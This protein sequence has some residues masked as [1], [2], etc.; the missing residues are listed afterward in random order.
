M[1]N[2]DQPSLF[3]FGVKKIKNNEETETS[4]NINDA[5]KY[6][7][8]K[9]PWTPPKNYQFPIE[10]QR[11][12]KF[13]FDWLIR[14][15]WLVYSEKVQGALCKCCVLFANN[16][17]GKRIHHK[18]GAL[19]IKPFTKWKDAIERFNRHSNSEYHK[20]SIIR[21]EEFIKVMEN[22][23]NNIANEI[24]I[25]RKKQVIENRSI[26]RLIIETL[27][28]CGKQNIALRGNNDSGKI[29]D[30]SIE[31]NDGNFRSLLRFKSLT[32]PILDKHLKNA[33]SFA[34]YTSPNVQNEII[35][36]C[37]DETQDVSRLEQ[38]S[39]CVRY[40]DGVSNC[41]MEDFLEFSIVHDMTGKGLSTSILQ[42]LEKFGLE[43]K[44]LVGQGYDGAASMSGQFNGVQQYIREAVP[45]ALFVHCASH[46]LN[47]AVGS[48]CKIVSIRNCIGT[49]SSVIT[50]FR[51]SS[52]RT[53]TLIESLHVIEKFFSLTLPLSIALQKVNIDL[54]YCYERVTDVC[55]IF[56]EIRE[57][58]DDE[59]KQIFS[60]VEESMLEGIIEVPRTVGRQTAQIKI[61]L[62][63]W[64][65]VSDRDRPTTSLTTLSA[66]SYDF[67]PNIH[68]LLTI[69]ATLPVTTATAERSFSTLRRLKT[70]LRNNMGETR[71]TGLALLNIYRNV[72][73]NVEEIIDRFAMLPRKWDFIL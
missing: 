39:F 62:A 54:S 23:K 70:Y 9:N 17:V 67:F 42:L 44:F 32:D 11:R 28:L 18:L 35:T 21:S 29:Y 19:I 7:L 15:P 55:Q 2:S 73:L 65:N 12:L 8:L 72:D 41:I 14:F 64:K 58:G 37:V 5:K 51:A 6:E 49:V 33:T 30:E 24:D 38:M 71:L 13:Q 16:S 56:K 3:N 34:S 61:W 36:I 4:N 47:L 50:F 26:L 22:K 69:L 46:S 25:S 10:Q 52:Q 40:V 63:K 59:F 68:S 20:L 60:N 1:K 48:S 43:K 53:K 57:N 45:H 27:I 31:T 66:M